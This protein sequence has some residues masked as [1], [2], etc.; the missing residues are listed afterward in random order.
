ME[1]IKPVK[2]DIDDP[3]NG[4]AF[5]LISQF[6][7]KEPNPLKTGGFVYG[8]NKVRGSFG[9]VGEAQKYAEF[10]AK[11]DDKNKIKIVETGKWFPF[12]NDPSMILEQHHV[13]DKTE[14]GEVQAGEK[15]LLSCFSNEADEKAKKTKQEIS[16]KTKELLEKDY[17]DDL[18]SLEYYTYKR[19][20]EMDLYNYIKDYETKLKHFQKV[21]ERVSKCI[22]KVETE[23][24]E[25]KE[26]WIECYNFHPTLGRATQ[27]QTEFIPGDNQYDLL[28]SY[29]F[30]DLD[31]YTIEELESLINK[32]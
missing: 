23:H 29:N 6:I 10:L 11:S 24:P 16:A 26:D 17:L 18:S 8:F 15:T 32:K 28:Y 5:T 9:T 30:T 7:M 21:H 3:I 12:S 1:T 31:D 19:R 22:R 13:S 25:F 20:T 2:K 4:Q 14:N 27:K